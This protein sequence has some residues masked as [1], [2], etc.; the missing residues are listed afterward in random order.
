MKDLRF[1]WTA[2]LLLGI[3]ACTDPGDAAPRNHACKPNPVSQLPPPDGGG[4]RPTPPP[5]QPM[6]PPPT[7][8]PHIAQSA[9]AANGAVAPSAPVE[10]VEP[11]DKGGSPPAPQPMIPPPTHPP[12]AAQGPDAIGPGPCEEADDEPQ[13]WDDTGRGEAVRGA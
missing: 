11:P 2:V 1:T 10:M 8:P 13:G 5:P 6:I 12:H 4:P 9:T 7:H 3:G